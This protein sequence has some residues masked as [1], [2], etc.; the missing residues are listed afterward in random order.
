[1]SKMLKKFGKTSEKGNVSE[2]AVHR[3]LLD[4]FP[5]AEVNHVGGDT[6]ES[7]DI[8]LIRKNQPV[9]MIENK[10]YNSRNV[11][12]MEVEK[13]IR[14]CEIQDTCGIM[15]SQHTGIANKSNFEL[16]VHGN[17]V[18]LFV[19]EVNFDADKIKTAINIVTHFKDAME[20]NVTN[21]DDHVIKPHILNDINKDFASY[22]AQKTAMLKMTKDNSD[23]MM[24]LINEMKLPALEAYLSPN[25][26]KS[27]GKNNNTC[28]YCE[29]FIPKSMAQHHRYCVKRGG[30]LSYAATAVASDKLTSSDTEESVTAEDVV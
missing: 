29:K 9:I 21:G 13:F 5:C 2:H 11:P 1:M 26:S 15:L 10:D 4:M 18:L 8:M 27:S 14:D 22:L 19:H 20:K 25:F 23:K 6:K 7:G 16:Q 17:L 30:K 3:I 28:V 24:T 12:G